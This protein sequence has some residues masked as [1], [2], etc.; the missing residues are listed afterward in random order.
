MGF[1]VLVTS[2]STLNTELNITHTGKGAFRAINDSAM[3]SGAGSGDINPGAEI[4]FVQAG[5]TPTPRQSSRINPASRPVTKGKLLHQYDVIK[6]DLLEMGRAAI[7]TVLSVLMAAQGS[8]DLQL[9]TLGLLVEIARRGHDISGICPEILEPLLASGHPEIRRKAGWLMLANNPMSA[10]PMI[11]R[12]LE[13][14]GDETVRTD[15]LAGLAASGDIQANRQMSV[16]PPST[17]L[18]GSN[19]LD[20]RRSVFLLQRLA[21]MAA[22]GE[23]VAGVTPGIMIR[24]WET[25]PEPEIRRMALIVLCYHPGIIATIFL[26]RLLRDDRLSGDNRQNVEASLAQRGD[27]DTLR[28]LVSRALSGDAGWPDRLQAIRRLSLLGER[29]PPEARS[30]LGMALLDEDARVRMEAVRAF[31]AIPCGE[32]EADV[33]WR[34]MESANFEIDVCQAIYPAIA[35]AGERAFNTLRDAIQGQTEHSG[36]VLAIRCLGINGQRSPDKTSDILV[37]ALC[38]EDKSL[39]E[40]T[41]RA[42]SL[43]IERDDLIM[44]RIHTLMTDAN[45]PVNDR[46]REGLNRAYLR[47]QQRSSP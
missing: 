19:V 29:M 30:A 45:A 13:Y 17:S 12:T 31:Y 15:M 41:L 16:F 24:I 20:H 7:P 34:M 37:E 26:K 39:F 27:P 11:L 5:D 28:Q 9:D 21:E 25:S 18:E 4:P 22:R 36:K 47:S 33:L 46:Q 35:M 32:A 6:K 8:D 2:H 38:Q 40:E 44:E 3:E 1:P 43:L 10:A 42:L 23:S 14:E